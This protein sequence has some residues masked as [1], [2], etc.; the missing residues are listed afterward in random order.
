MMG[1]TLPK[2]GRKN[3]DTS[4]N[5]SQRGLT[6]AGQDSGVGT[7]SSLAISN[8]GASA[9][10]PPTT[11]KSAEHGRST[12]A[13]SNAG[14]G[15][16]SPTP[17][18]ERTA[19]ASSSGEEARSS[20]LTQ[21]ASVSTG[22]GW[23]HKRYQ[24]EDEELWG[25]GISRTGQQ[26]MDAIKHAGTSAGRF[27]EAK[28]GMEKQVTDQ[29]R[30]DFY[31]TP[32]NPP[33]NDYHPPVVSSRPQHPDGHRWMLQPPP[34]AKV[35]EG[36]VPV[37]R[38][39]SVA[40]ANSRRTVATTDTLPLGRL[41]GERA[42]EA[43]IRKGDNS[44]EGA[45]L[46]TASLSGIFT[47]RTT[48][49]SSTRTRSQRTARSRSHSVSTESEGSP[50][51]GT[52]R[53]KR[54]SKVRARPPLDIDSDEEDEWMSRNTEYLA[55]SNT[56]PSNH[57]THAAQRPRLSTILSS[58]QCATSETTNPLGD[59]TNIRPAMPSSSDSQDSA[60]AGSHLAQGP[61]VAE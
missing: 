28:L 31:F 61:A 22:D 21:T 36:K 16:V 55:N 15:A 56:A 24:R 14:N 46:S 35:M 59:V 26:L 39:A 47:Q 57:P 30:R 40:S 41:V 5:P 1:P 48:R 20:T 23:N 18:S 53:T 29:D 45:A 58:E 8:A 43:K 44:A 37:S 3:V 50:S 12:S 9:T 49:G 32:K 4:K 7:R 11:A 13:S 38:S 51:G 27:V 10:E 33:V 19:V 6:S 42:V 17:Q 60:A 54:K 34:S 2:K 52:R 25:H